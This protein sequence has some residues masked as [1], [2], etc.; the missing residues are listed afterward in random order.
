FKLQ[1]NDEITIFT[2]PNWYDTKKVVLKGEVRFPGTY[3]VSTGEKLSNIIQR[4]G[5]FTKEAFIAGAVFS[6]ESIKV[7]EAKRMNEAMLK[8][9]QQI[10]F[11]STNVKQAGQKDTTTAELVSTINLLEKQADEYEPLGRLVV[12][13]DSDIEKFKNSE[14]DIRL[15]NKDTLIVP[16]IND[17][18]SVYGEVMNPSSFIYNSENKIED[19]IEKAGSLTQRAD[20]EA[21]YIVFANGEA[22]KIGSGY[23]F[24]DFANQIKK[25]STIIVPMKVSSVSNILLWKEVSQIVYQ[26]AVTAASIK[27]VG[28]L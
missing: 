22:K 17:T 18:V 10:S 19:Y 21:M 12:Y 7:N 5:G 15:E 13:L 23:L 9:K 24:N 1:D 16:S 2:I 20:E 28:G 4:A 14:F 3:T 26:L 6:R 11:L 27:T 25:G 8:L